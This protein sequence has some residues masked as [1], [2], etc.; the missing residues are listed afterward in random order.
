MIDPI[1]ESVRA[2]LLARSQ[3]GLAKY[4]VGLDRTDLSR[5][6]WLNHAQQEALDLANYLEV[7]IQEAERG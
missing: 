6:E 2:K 1:V 4:G 7:L 3:V 5:L